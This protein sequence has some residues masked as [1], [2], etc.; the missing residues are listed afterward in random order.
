MRIVVTPL[1]ERH[2]FCR[3][4]QSVKRLYAMLPE[5]GSIQREANVRHREDAETLSASAVRDAMEG[6]K[7]QRR[8]RQDHPKTLG[9]A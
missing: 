7:E 2:M 5:K 9:L 8:G 6:K 4:E 1:I 3:L